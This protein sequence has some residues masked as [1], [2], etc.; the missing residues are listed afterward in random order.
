MSPRKPLSTIFTPADPT[1]SMGCPRPESAWKC[2]LVWGVSSKSGVPL[3]KVSLNESCA[4]LAET[5][6]GADPV[7]VQGAGHVGD[8]CPAEVHVRVAGL[9]DVCAT[10]C[11]ALPQAEM[12]ATARAAMTVRLQI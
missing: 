3:S 2:V 6:G 10:G 12:S 8:A 9:V 5:I 1:R 7:R 11:L 4:T